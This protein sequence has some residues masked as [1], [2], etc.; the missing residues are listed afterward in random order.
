MT[1]MARCGRL[2][3]S[4]V[5]VAAA[6][7]AT[8]AEA[9]PGDLDLT[10]GGDGKV[11]TDLTDRRDDANDMAIQANGRIVVVGRTNW[12]SYYGSFGLA[13]YR[14]DGHL[15]AAFGGDGIVTTNTAKREDS[16][17]AV[18]I[19]PDG[20]IVVVGTASLRLPRRV[21][22]IVRYERDGTLDASFGM[23]G[24]VRVGFSPDGQADAADVAIQ[25][26]GKIV[27][28]GTSF[29]LDRFAVARLDPDGTLDTTFNTDGKA[30]TKVS[31]G[32]D[33]A[34]AVAIQPD[35]KILVAGESWTP[36]GWDGIDVVR[37]QTDGHLDQTFGNDG[38]ARV[39]LTEGSDGPGDA[40]RGIATQP[41]GKIV[42]AGDATGGAEYTSAFGLARFG[43]DGTA[44]VTF[45]GDGK[46]ITNFTKWDDSASDLAI[47]PDGKIVAVG[48]AGYSWD[49]VA[50]F[51]LVR[52]DADGM[53]DG[54]FGD[55]GKLRTR[56]RAIAP[57]APVD[58]VGAWAGAVAIQA[59][60]RIVAAGSLNRVVD[61]HIDGRF[62][63][64]RYRNG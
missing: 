19:Q 42:V 47:Q 22:A 12:R 52:Y 41:D 56:F 40:A 61:D 25:P 54:S 18:A 13:R 6:S 28:V 23:N 32:A 34:E 38:V 21:F 35:G 15:D 1:S 37:Y 29:D 4:L 11:V 17:S 39:D 57:D 27:V 14:T 16:A 58:I 46:V 63:L 44:D 60:G 2:T 59:D 26:D 43:D 10:F 48:V 31:T 20:K 49:T 53:L 50:T 45:H 55:G 30:T 51:A 7:G 62:A 3:L 9:A 36:S 24:K 64:A 33:S 5:I 8:P